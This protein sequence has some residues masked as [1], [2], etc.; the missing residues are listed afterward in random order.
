MHVSR[1]LHDFSGRPTCI[2]QSSYIDL[3]SLLRFMFQPRCALCVAPRQLLGQVGR[4]WLRV[5]GL[6]AEMVYS[7]C[8]LGRTACA[9]EF[10]P[11]IPQQ[12]EHTWGRFLHA[13]LHRICVKTQL[14]NN[15]ECTNGSCHQLIL[16]VHSHLRIGL[17]FRL[18]SCCM[19]FTSWPFLP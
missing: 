6:F 9:L 8:R 1:N 13:L 5:Q 7:L 17:I 14:L 3:N 4:T 19:Q 10:P 18:Y 2:L 12:M 16:R 11:P 15:S